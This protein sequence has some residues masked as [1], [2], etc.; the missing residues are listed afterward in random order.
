MDADAKTHLVARRA[1]GVLLGDCL[2][3]RD[4][5]LD[6]V[7]RAGEIRHHAVAGGVE[8]SA[9]MGGDQPIENR[10][11]RL[12]RPQGADFVHAHQTAVLGDVGR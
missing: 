11:V 5:T 9:M 3:H 10:P 12:K 2:L 8:N 6:R 1:I 4:R 7:H